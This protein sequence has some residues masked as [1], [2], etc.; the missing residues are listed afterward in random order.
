MLSLLST[1]RALAVRQQT[2]EALRC[3]HLT[4]VADAAR[5]GTREKARKKK[6]KVEVKKLGFIPHN[7]R[8]KKINVKRADKHVDDSWKQVPRDDVYVGRYYRWPVYT[9]AEAIQCHRETHHPS[10]YN[11]P[12]A[13]LSIEV[14]LN[15]QGEKATRFVDN[16]QRMAMIPHK[17]EHG[18]DRKI[19]VF[20]KGHEEIT[21]AREAG[22]SL[23][24]GVELIKD[25]T[26][27]ELL[28]SDY[29]YIIAHPNI[30]PELVALRGLMKRKFPN[31]K[32]ETLGPNLAEMIVKFSNGIS[33]SAAKDEYQQN[34]GLIKANVGTL[35]MDALHLEENIRCLLQDI[36]TMRPKREGRFVTR[37]LLKSA[38]SSEQLKIDPFVYIP[39]LYDKSAA[40]ASREAKKQA[41]PV[42][43]PQAAAAAAN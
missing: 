28:L 22:A 1:M 13:P 24:G 39:E 33:Y 38:P 40:K 4:A 30:L 9:V 2:G 8:D 25:I 19:I 16:F 36:N 32:N 5:K 6:V 26:E 11:V 27:G 20:T 31:P 35:E 7:Q 3:L 42:E 34:F 43:E 18:E 17:F 12:N 10:M 41:E 21:Q 14:E 37:V 23:V 29:Q 15:M